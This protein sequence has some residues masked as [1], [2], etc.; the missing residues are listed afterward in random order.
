MCRFLALV[1]MVVLSQGVQGQLLVNYP[2]NPDE[3]GNGA[4]GVED[5]LSLL[6]LFATEFTPVGIAVEGISLEEYLDQL[7]SQ[8][9]SLQAA[10]NAGTSGT[11]GVL[12]VT[13]NPDN[14]LSFL[15]ADGTILQTPLLVG[16][17]GPPGPQGPMPDAEDFTELGLHFLP[18]AENEPAGT[19]PVWNGSE[20]TLLLPGCT[21][22]LADNFSPSALISNGS[23]S[24]SG[25][26]Q[27]D[28]EFSVTFDG[29]DY[30]LVGIGTQC[31]FKE[32]L[33]S[34]HYRN[35][36]PIPGEL[37]NS[38]WSST[39][40]GAQV[41][42]ENDSTYLEAFGRYY[43]RFAVIDSRGLCPSGWHV[44]SDDDW[45]ELEVGLGMPE[46]QNL[47]NGN[48]GI[49]QG[50][51][52]KASVFDT[53]SWDG[54]NSSGFSALPGGSAYTGGGFAPTGEIG[55]WWSSTSSSYGSNGIQRILYTGYPRIYRMEA[56]YREGLSVRCVKE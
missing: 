56:N 11:P 22:P 19:I 36:D 1:F 15:F 29:Y 20:W 13:V 53:P 31:W 48:R 45:L 37:N 38:D 50:T 33:R 47:Y 17:Q 6:S 34:S 40:S 30:A 16:P 8:I 23:C 41:F 46:N 51:Q 7:S 49:D 21:D 9:A 54:S 5:L 28:G 4:I 18:N 26:P 3:N 14:T 55:Q 25:P 24:Y 43:N 2:Y 39:T 10:L 35:G 42:S 27:C 32:N 52:L 12:D 44:P